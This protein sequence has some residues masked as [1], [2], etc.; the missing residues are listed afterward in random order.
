MFLGGI[1]NSGGGTEWGS[2]HK[3]WIYSKCKIKY[4]YATTLY[5]HL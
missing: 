5:E 2:K 1:S 3:V 4:Q